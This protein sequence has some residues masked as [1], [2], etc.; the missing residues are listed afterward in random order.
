LVVGLTLV[1]G[2]ADALGVLALGGAF[3]S[4]MTG[5]MVLLGLSAGTRDP[6]LAIS[7]SSA[8]GAY[9][10]GVLVG[11]RIAGVPDPNDALWP[12]QVTWALSLELVAMLGFLV[13]WEVLLADG[14]DKTAQLI[15]LMVLA[16]ALGIQGSAVQRFGVSG[17]SSTYLTGTLTGLIAGV[18][19]RRPWRSLLPSAE[20]LAALIV[21][22]GLGAAVLVYVPRLAPIVLVVPLVAVMI[23]GL[24]LRESRRD[25]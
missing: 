4:V 16:A 22:A 24:L 17:L 10:V 12:R 15:M 25:R 21:G 18:A 3:S 20:L 13:S 9:I 7:A 5:N 11:S 1:T 19:M 14:F 23:G 2:I 6:Q 8:I